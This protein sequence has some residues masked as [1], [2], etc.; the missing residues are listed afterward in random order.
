MVFLLNV[1]RCRGRYRL[2]RKLKKFL[3]EETTCVD[4]QGMKA[5]T[6]LC[7]R[8]HCRYLTGH[9]IINNTSFAVA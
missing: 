7:M 5:P 9:R 8:Y 2:G 6:V 1:L 4:N 3:T